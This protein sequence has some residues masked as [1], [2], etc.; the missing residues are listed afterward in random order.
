LNPT[1][2]EPYDK[3]NNHAVATTFLDFLTLRASGA[4]LAADNVFVVRD[5]IPTVLYPQPHCLD[6]ES[7]LKTIAVSTGPNCSIRSYV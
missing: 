2:A 3:A 4:Y 5:L 1:L 6:I 7:T